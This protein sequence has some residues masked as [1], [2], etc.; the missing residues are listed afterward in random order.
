M[1]VK[2]NL[3]N[4]SDHAQVASY[5][6]EAVSWAVGTGLMTGKSGNLLDPKGFATRAE[7]AA[8]FQRLES[9]V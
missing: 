3:N 1:T 7:V 9:L 2:G 6:Q 4:F 5:A 8:M